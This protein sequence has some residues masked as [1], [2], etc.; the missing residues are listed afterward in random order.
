MPVDNP[1]HDARRGSRAFTLV[2]LLIVIGILGLLIALLL[3]AVQAAREAARR[4]QCA[5]QLRQLGLA[6]HQHVLAKGS[7][8]PGVEQWYFNSAVSHRGV[9]LFAFLL[10]Y[11]E[12]SSALVKWDYRDPIHNAENGEKANTAVILPLLLCPSDEISTNPIKVSGRD[13]VYALTSYGGNGGTRSYFPMQSTAD[14]VFHTTGEASEPARWQ[15]AVTPR[16]I[17]DGLSNTLL[18]GERSHSDLNYSTFNAAGWGEPL[19]EWGWWGASASRKMIGHVTLSAWA[20]LNYQ[21]PFSYGERAGQTP[22]AD[23]FS[24]FN[25]NYVDQRICA[26]GSNHPGGANMALADGS[27]RFMPSALEWDILRRLSTRA[28]HEPAAE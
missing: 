10:P 24:E 8:P 21:L 28:G 15:R 25:S 1:F 4:V 23:S 14:G 2:E 7:F 22:P 5:S 20:P 27:A 19:Q 18:F 12:Q 6:A 11:L 3:P 16:D 17:A 9:P 13:W 26:Y